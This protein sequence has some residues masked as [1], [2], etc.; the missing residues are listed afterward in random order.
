LFSA[1]ELTRIAAAPI[2]DWMI[3]LHPDQRVVVERASDGPVRV[4]GAAGTGKTV[5]ALHRA[6]YLAER[7]RNTEPR[8]RI[9]F[10]TVT[11]TLPRVYEHLFLRLPA[12]EPGAVDFMR[13]D[14]IAASSRT[15]RAGCTH[16]IGTRP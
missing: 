13:I 2:E 1:D 9:L 14:D 11:D 12:A 7:W 3:F 6:S 15:F 8:A 5:V 4:R 10:T 16:P